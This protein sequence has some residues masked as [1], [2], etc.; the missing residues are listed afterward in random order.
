MLKKST[1]KYENKEVEFEFETE[2]TFLDMID[3]INH[4]V[5]TVFAEAV[6]YAPYFVDYYTRYYMVSYLATGVVLPVDINDCYKF[7]NKSGII[8]AMEEEIADTFVFVK[9]N[10][11]D[12]VDYRK[13]QLMKRSK[14]DDLLNA[15]V[16]LV[17][18]FTKE[19]EGVDLNRIASVMEKL[20]VVPNM[21]DSQIV[22]ALLKLRKEEKE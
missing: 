10:I 1:Y 21:S 11:T 15:A 5:E 22:Q 8:E 6:E 14:I 12:L 19:F 18:T 3:I 4:T 9:S 7:L 20:Q 17:N 13:E 2:P 16:H